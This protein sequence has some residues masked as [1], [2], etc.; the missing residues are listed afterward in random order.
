MAPPEPPL[1][2]LLS[3]LENEQESLIVNFPVKLIVVY[4]APPL[5]P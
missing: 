4:I 1:P 3:Q 5:V 2:I